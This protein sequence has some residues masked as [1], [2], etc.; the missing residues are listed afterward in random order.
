MHTS[1]QTYKHRQFVY[2][3][4][5]VYG[6]QCNFIRAGVTHSNYFKPKI[7]RAA[8][9]Y[10]DC[11]AAVQETKATRKNATTII[12]LVFQQIINEGMHQ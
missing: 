12:G 2:N 4:I 10:T 11:I 6:S 3:A 5:C 8:K 7:K 9:F 1:I